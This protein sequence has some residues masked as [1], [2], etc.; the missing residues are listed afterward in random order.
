MICSN[1]YYFNEVNLLRP[2]ANGK[3]YPCTKVNTPG[4]RHWSEKQKAPKT[5]ADIKFKETATITKEVR[6]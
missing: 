1:C 4:G 3:V 2:L 5:C 6:G